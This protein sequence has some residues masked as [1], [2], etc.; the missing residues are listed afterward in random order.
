[1]FDFTLPVWRFGE[2]LLHAERVARELGDPSATVTFRAGWTGLKGRRLTS[3]WR[4]TI[5]HERHA[6]EDAV[7]Q[8]L[9]VRADEISGTLPSLL[10]QL[11]TP[12]YA[13]F[14]FFEMPLN[15]IEDELAEMRT[16]R[17]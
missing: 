1:V 6:H 9:Q 13:Q 4:R 3:L 15:V 14:D 10:E 16:G 7:V 17:G 12:L 11:L 8:Y 5:L 2:A